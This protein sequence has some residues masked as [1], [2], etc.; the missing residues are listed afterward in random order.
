L[1]LYKALENFVLIAESVLKLSPRPKPSNGHF[2]L[3]IEFDELGNYQLSIFDVY[4]KLYYREDFV[5]QVHQVEKSLN[6]QHL[7]QGSYIVK[8]SSSSEQA[9]SLFTIVGKVLC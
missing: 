3:D 9:S 6:L 5:A 2:T 8:L 4:G 1:N 7:H